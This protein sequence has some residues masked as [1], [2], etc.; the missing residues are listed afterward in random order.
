MS[1][2]NLADRI[3][4]AIAGYEEGAWVPESEATIS[5][6]ITGKRWKHVL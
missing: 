2:P 6:I 1:E 4:R 3:H 5:Q